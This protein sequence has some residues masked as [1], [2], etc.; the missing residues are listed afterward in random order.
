[1]FKALRDAFYIELSEIRNSYYK[2]FLITLFPVFSFVLIIS[3]FYQGVA[4]KL[5]LT[6]VD[7]D[8]SS[9]SRKLLSNIDASP[10]LQILSHSL[11]TKDAIDLVKSSEVYGVVIIPAHFEKNTLL[12]SGPKVTVMLN[13]QYILIGKILTAALTETVG[14]SAA[15]VEFV[16]SL[17]STQNSQ[18]SLENISPIGL[19]ITPFFNT[20]KNYFLFLVSALLPSIWQIFIVIA[21]IVSFGTLFKAKKE[22]EFFGSEYIAFK[23]IGKLL[24]YTFVYTLMGSLFL[25]Y[26]YGTLA[27]VFE[28]S[29]AVTIF[30]LFVTVVAYQVIALLLFVSGFDYA[31]SLSLGAV[32]TAPAFAFLGVTFPIYN[33]NQFALFWRD[34]LPISHYMELQIS[35]ANYGADIYLEIDKLLIIMLFWLLFIPVVMR[36]RQRL[37][38]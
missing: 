5:P 11:S 32:Y 3:I 22:R 13:T 25:F 14:Y 23:I 15:E 2:L 7:N 38:S 36:F 35:Q 27:W 6:V 21:T 28:G 9:L 1:M 34:L 17:A 37:A 4:F 16:E 19:Q 29:F 18:L 20:Y 31:R 30:G 26:I 10:T 24:P 8:K 33:M 12:R